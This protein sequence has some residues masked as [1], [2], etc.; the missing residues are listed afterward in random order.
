VP[1]TSLKLQGAYNVPA[2]PG[3]AL[4]GFITHEGQRMV[5]PD[6]SVATPGWT[7]LDLGARYTQNLGAGGG[8]SGGGL[9]R[10]LVWR[11][12]I[13]NITNQRAW[14]EAPYQYGHAFLYP[15]AP[16]V[17]HASAALSF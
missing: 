13:D 10:T 2:L 16:R 12:G 15:L 9:V 14:K 5:A 6:N 7:R 4:L 11:L 8:G 17:F 3:L 1:A